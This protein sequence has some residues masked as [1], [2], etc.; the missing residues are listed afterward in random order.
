MDDIKLGGGQY[1]CEKC[2][3]THFGST[4]HIC[5]EYEY[6]N[7]PLSL[8]AS[9]YICPPSLSIM[10]FSTEPLPMNMI[11][12]DTKTG[13]QVGRFYEEDG[14]LKFEGHASASAE[15]FIDF[16]CMSFHDRVHCLAKKLK[17]N[18]S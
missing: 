18:N 10:T 15:I 14:E 12:T 7:N 11:F 16:V 1:K 9:D 17:E 6:I 2:G 13:H 3:R 4:Q 8:S 5:N